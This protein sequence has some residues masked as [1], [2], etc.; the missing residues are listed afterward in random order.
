MSCIITM[1]R[2]NEKNIPFLKHQYISQI[3][4]IVIK[5]LMDIE[6]N[7]WKNFCFSPYCSLSKFILCNLDYYPVLKPY[8]NAKT[9]AFDFSYQYVLDNCTL[10]NFKCITNTEVLENNTYT[11]Q[12]LAE[13]AYTTEKFCF[14]ELQHYPI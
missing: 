3:P 12:W 11:E 10:T 6:L 2:Y 1:I 5:Q 7:E 14:I 9:N 4:L 8:I 13:D